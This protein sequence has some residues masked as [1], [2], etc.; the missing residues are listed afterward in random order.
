MENV[1][2]KSFCNK[3]MASVLSVATVAAMG[4][5][6]ALADPVDTISVPVTIQY[7]SVTFDDTTGAVTLGTVENIETTV[8]NVVPSSTT[9]VES[10]V[11]TAI[12]SSEWKDAS[13]EEVVTVAGVTTTRTK[14]DGTIIP[15]VNGWIQVEDYYEE[16]LHHAALDTLQI[17][18][19]TYGTKTADTSA[20]YRGAG[21]TYSG[22]S[23][24]ESFNPYA[25]MDN[26]Y[27]VGEGAQIELVYNYYVYDK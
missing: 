18:T 1:S 27:I 8:E 4:L 9:T 26:N 23:G 24:E 6:M 14:A 7:R 16:A 17:G 20:Q 15:V 22:S 2:I 12:G 5:S 21:W 13:T 3:L 25:Y 11:R 19:A 10:V